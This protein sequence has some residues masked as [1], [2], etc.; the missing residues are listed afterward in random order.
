MLK[1]IIPTLMLAP[2]TLKLKKNMLFPSL[3]ISSTILGMMS[4]QWLKI[5]LALNKYTSP[6][7]TIDQ[8][9]S[10]LI[11]LSCWLLPMTILASQNHMKHTTETQKQMLLLCLITLQLFLIITLSATNLLLFFIMFEATLI[12]TMMI[13]TRWGN[14]KERL[15]AGMYFMFYTLIS[16]MPLLVALLLINHQ[17]NSLNT[18]LMHFNITSEP[19]NILWLSCTMAFMVKMPLY[20]LHLWLPKA[21]VEAPIAGS[22][23]LAAILL[24]LGG[25]GLL[26]TSP[27]L[28]S[29][30]TLYYPFIILALWGMIMASLICLQQ[31]DLKS[32]I[33]YSSV[34]HMGLVITATMIQTPASLSGAMM[35]M[36]AHGITSSM[37]FCLANTMYERTNTRTMTMMQ[38]AQTLI[39]LMTT[40]WLL[41]NLTNMAFPPSVNLMGEI[42]IITT[43][44]S[45]ST[46]TL[47]LSASAATI[48]A[49][50][51]IHMFTTAQQ[52]K[53]HKDTTFPPAQTRE[54][55]LLTL[56]LM[57]TALLMLNPQTISLT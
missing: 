33:A 38:G 46:P 41:A 45:W 1:I 51:S 42:M 35:L 29:T 17:N 48:T 47:I 28:L 13:I 24:K 50:Y 18:L 9:S 3:V 40:F 31:P 49:I 32:L 43:A 54:Y 5:P 4:L 27:I 20:G 30:Q 22:M 44:F 15:L 53:M 10:P 16:S 14:Q 2:M 23:V 26:R 56:H 19:N 6:H 55:L 36:M 57:P 52:G 34:S 37:L 7:M 12:P 39:P 25:Y 21:H 11:T 8:I